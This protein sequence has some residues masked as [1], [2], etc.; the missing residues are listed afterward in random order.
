VV[1]LKQLVEVVVA[2]YEQ[3]AVG[4]Q[5]DAHCVQEPRDAVPESAVPQARLVVHEG[6]EAVVRV[7]QL[8]LPLLEERILAALGVE[9][10]F[11]PLANGLGIRA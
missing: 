5:G 6:H 9:G 8:L 10:V 2:L 3:R 7:L 4:A 1:G 11:E